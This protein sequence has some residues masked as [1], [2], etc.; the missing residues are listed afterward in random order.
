MEK[1]QVTME[2]AR[3]LSALLAEEKAEKSAAY[4]Q[5]LVLRQLAR[6]EYGRRCGAMLT[7]ERYCRNCGKHRSAAVCGRL[8]G[9][10]RR[11][12]YLKGYG[13]DIGGAW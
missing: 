4:L 2:Q 6:E 11:L 10:L 1:L 3:H 12:Y 13:K 7:A 8:Y 9:Q 5:L